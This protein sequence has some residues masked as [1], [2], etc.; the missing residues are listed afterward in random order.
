MTADIHMATGAAQ[1]GTI[2]ILVVS[3]R[4]NGGFG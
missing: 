1:V 3:T 2:A 4:D